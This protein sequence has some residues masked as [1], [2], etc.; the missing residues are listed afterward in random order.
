MD[1]ASLGGGWLR[2]G[3]EQYCCCGEVLTSPVKGQRGFGFGI[4]HDVT[5]DVAC[6]C[7][8][9]LVKSLAGCFP[10][11]NLPKLLHSLLFLSELGVQ[12]V[13]LLE[14]GHVTQG[15][16]SLTHL[17]W[18]P[19]VWGW[20]VVLPRHAELVPFIMLLAPTLKHS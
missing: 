10:I 17:H 13:E 5:M 2:H 18:F 4:L 1:L 12:L 6:L 16:L 14:V 19:N 8:C 7:A 9:S 15:G 20:H 3:T 11:E